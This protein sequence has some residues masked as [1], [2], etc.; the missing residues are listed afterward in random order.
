[1]VAIL[2]AKTSGFGYPWEDA[3]KREDAAKRED[4][5]K[6]QRPLRRGRGVTVPAF[7]ASNVH[8][9]VREEAQMVKDSCD[10]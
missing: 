8:K 6:P 5:T 3:T 2:A 7:F 9:G 1:M 4:A 10:W